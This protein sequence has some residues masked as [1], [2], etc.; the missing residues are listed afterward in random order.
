MADA[1]QAIPRYTAR[2]RQNC[3][4]CHQNPTGGGLRSLYASQFL[5][6]TEMALVRFSQERIDR[7]HPDVS[8]SITVGT[9]I[10]TI[11]AYT[12]KDRPERNFFQMQGDLYVAFEVDDRFSANLNVDQVGSVEAYGLG[13]VLPWS[14]YVKIGRFTPVFG[15]KLDDHNMFVREELWFDQP[16]NTDAGVEVGFYPEHFSVWASALNGDPGANTVWDSNRELAYVGGAFGRFGLAGVGIGIGGSIWYNPKE[17]AG[18]TTGRRTAGGPYGY[19][20]WGPLSWLWEV[21]ASQLEGVSGQNPKTALITSHEVSWQLK[22]G[23]DLLATFN[24]VDRDIDLRTGTRS[25]YGGGVAMIPTPF[26]QVQAAVNV[27]RSDCP[28]PGQLCP[29]APEPD[30]FRSEFQVHLF[31]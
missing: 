29:D 9:D 21:D 3:T 23:L 11:H 17:L 24:Y 20:N 19:V 10:R 16:F 27:Y 31:S 4:L 2:Y 22:R 26:V 14:G 5:V 28:D 8:S 7:I 18:L 25:R 30:F 12:D 6:P 15:W 1:T 13:W